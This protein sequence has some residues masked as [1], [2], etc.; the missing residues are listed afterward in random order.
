MY[1]CIPPA[2]AI[3]TPYSSC[4]LMLRATP[5]HVGHRRR[6]KRNER[7]ISAA[8][9]VLYGE[10]AFSEESTV[11][12]RHCID[13][14]IRLHSAAGAG[15]PECAH[16][17]RDFAHRSHRLLELDQIAVAAVTVVNI[18]PDNLR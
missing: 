10:A 9:N 8:A 4:E 6:K 11:C 14:P 16:E 18:M 7:G 13:R 17:Q 1:V 3:A 15:C 2:D 5:L 12:I